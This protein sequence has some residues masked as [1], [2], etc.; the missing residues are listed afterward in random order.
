[1][2]LKAISQSCMLK[3]NADTDTDMKTGRRQPKREHNL[4]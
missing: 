4:E 3:E 2:S 1:V